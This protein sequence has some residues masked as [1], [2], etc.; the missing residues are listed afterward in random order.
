MINKFSSE[1][2][3]QKTST[4]G[5]VAAVYRVHFLMYSV[6]IFLI[7][8][9]WRQGQH[10]FEKERNISLNNCYNRKLLLHVYHL[11]RD[12][13]ICVLSMPFLSVTLTQAATKSVMPFLFQ[14]L[15]V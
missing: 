1:E 11:I 10:I 15:K 5:A 8:N 3:S 12:I 4:V 14:V 13:I 2:R 7:R 9:G 6:M